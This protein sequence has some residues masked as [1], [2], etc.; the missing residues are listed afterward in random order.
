[1]AKQA[2]NSIPVL[3]YRYQGPK[4]NIGF[5]LSPF[6]KE[7]NQTEISFKDMLF[8]YNEDFNYIRPLLDKRFPMIHPYTMETMNQFDPCWDNPIGKEIWM[9]ILAELQQQNVEE[10]EL[11]LF[12]QQFHTWISERLQ[13]AE[14]IEVTGNL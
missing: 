9:D 14:G 5:H 13:S 2:N 12:L 8:I 4:R 7:E 11:Q 10:E 1:M 3:I 6:N